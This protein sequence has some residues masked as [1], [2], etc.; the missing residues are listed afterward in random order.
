MMIPW[1]VLVASCDLEG[2]RALSG[3]LREQGI[4]PICTSSVHECEQIVAAEN[5]GLIFCDRSLSDGDYRD[6]LGACRTTRSKARVV[7]TSRH[8]DWD[9]YLEA[10]RLGAFDVI[11]APCRPTDVEWMVIQAKHDDRNRPAHHVPFPEERLSARAATA[12]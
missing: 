2:R 11:A 4:D 7:I 6:L 1:Q 9:E 8:A 5:V 12:R 3:I 10:I